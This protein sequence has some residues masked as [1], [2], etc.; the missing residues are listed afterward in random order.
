M[1]QNNQCVRTETGSGTAAAPARVPPQTDAP[2]RDAGW[3]EARRADQVADLARTLETLRSTH[4]ELITHNARLV[5]RNAELSRVNEDLT[6]LLSSARLPIVFLGPELRVRRFT[7]AA[8]QVLGLTGLDIGRP[9]AE[10]R[11]RIRLDDLEG[12][13]RDVIRDVAVVE[14]EVQGQDGRWFHLRIQPYRTSDHSV[15]GAV[16]V[17]LDVDGL[18]RAAQELQRSNRDLEN[19]ASFASHELREPLRNMHH[20]LQLM[21]SEEL[22]EASRQDLH[23]AT[24][25]L[26]R[27]MRLVTA[28]LR[29]SQVGRQRLERHRVDLDDVVHEARET[30]VRSLSEADASIEV[31]GDLPVVDGDPT[32]LADLFT[33]MFINAVQNRGRDRPRIRV[34]ARLHAGMV[35]VTVQDNGTG[36][37]LENPDDVFELFQRGRVARVEGSGIGLALCRKV[38]ELHGGHI[39][40]ETTPGTG[41]AFNFTL[42]TQR[43]EGEGDAVA[44]N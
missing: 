6:N 35:R 26:A 29:F 41:T 38:V 17:L 11:P 19:F 25:N 5:A 20:Y 21:D 31:E 33:N 4:E 10:L 40:V 39:W 8:E 12:K 23:R 2:L 37:D 1:G 28:L 43:S 13:T 14:H 16:L 32:L 27:V 42:P 34:S 24:Q 15:D 22:P 9:L 36:I 7:P 18:K 30:A 44:L 3:P